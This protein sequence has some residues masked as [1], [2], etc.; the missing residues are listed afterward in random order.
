MSDDAASGSES[1]DLKQIEDSNTILDNEIT[2][3]SP[4]F[5]DGNLI[6]EVE[7]S[8]FKVYGGLLALHSAIFKDMLAMP[9]PA[10]HDASDYVDG[11]PIVR[12]E[13][14]VDD[15]G[16]VLAALFERK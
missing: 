6:I 2:P 14:H 11:C 12:L 16:F 13:D 5:E 4:W 8:R 10:I 3:S 1:S 9:R 7:T 15:W